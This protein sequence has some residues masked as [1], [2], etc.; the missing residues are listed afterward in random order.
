MPS[1]SK[2]QQRPMQAAE[3][4]A[5]FPAAKQIRASMTPAQI[6]DFTGGSMKGKPEHVK[7]RVAHRVS[8]YQP[9][10]KGR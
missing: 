7:P 3:H 2:S 4:G 8:H 9:T 10:R 1:V 5:T 6:D